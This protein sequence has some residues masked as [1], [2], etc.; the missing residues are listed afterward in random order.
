MFEAFNEILADPA[1]RAEIVGA[2]IETLILIVPA[3]A[4]Y[5]S[6]PTRKAIRRLRYGTAAPRVIIGRAGLAV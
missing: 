6:I 5:V 2:V 1:S 3:A 4:Y